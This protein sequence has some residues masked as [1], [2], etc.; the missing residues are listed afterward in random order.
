[1]GDELLKMKYSRLTWWS[2]FSKNIFFIL[3]IISYLKVKSSHYSFLYL[4]KYHLFG[5]NNVTTNDNEYKHD[6]LQLNDEV[7]LVFDEH[8]LVFLKLHK[9]HQLNTLK[10]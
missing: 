6:L 9:F 1:M 3:Q 5:F 10:N 4:N 2:S 8:Y 7:H